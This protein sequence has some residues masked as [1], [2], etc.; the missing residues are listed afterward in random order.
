[1]V[2]S[3]V[4]DNLLFLEVGLTI[5]TFGLMKQRALEFVMFLFLTENVGIHA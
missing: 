3:S 5:M 4:F 1:M 2:D